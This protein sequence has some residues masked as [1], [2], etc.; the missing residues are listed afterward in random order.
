[1]KIFPLQTFLL[2]YA[3][4]QTLEYKFPSCL[5][6]ISDN[7]VIQTTWVEPAVLCEAFAVAMSFAIFFLLIKK[8]LP[9]NV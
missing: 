4:L 1:M 7:S 9:L 8:I 6:T 3:P 5:I 2:I